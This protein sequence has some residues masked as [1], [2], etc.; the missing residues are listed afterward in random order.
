MKILILNPPK[1]P[2]RQRLIYEECVNKSTSGHP[3]KG[4]KNIETLIVLYI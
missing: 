3:S 4:L 1:K 2:Q